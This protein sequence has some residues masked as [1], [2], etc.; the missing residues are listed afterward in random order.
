MNF[1]V[2]RNDD[3]ASKLAYELAIPYLVAKILVNRGISNVEDGRCFLYGDLPDIP[4]PFLFLEM[5]KAVDRIRRAIKR[6]ERIFIFGDYDADGISATA[7]LTRGLA[8]L[9]A[10]VVP[11]IPNRLSHGYG[12]KK[13]YLDLI[14]EKG[15]S[16]VITVDN[17]IKAFDFGEE[18]EREGLDFIITDHH[19]PDEQLPKAFAIIN[20]HVELE[21]YPDKHLAGV[22][23]AFKLLQALFI[24]YGKEAALLPYLKV[25]ALGTVADMVELKGENR[26]L[27]KKGL[28]Q[29]NTSTAYG[30]YH[31]IKSAGLLN[32]KLTTVDIAFRLAPRLNAAG[33]IEDPNLALKLLLSRNEQE[34]QQLAQQLNK[35]NASRQKIEERIL[36]EALQMAEE[37]EDR[38]I[39]L[40][41]PTWHRG[42]IGIVA[43]KLVEKFE[44]PVFLFELSDGIAYGSGRSVEGIPLIEG[45][46]AARQHLLSYGGHELAAGAVLEADKLELVKKIVNEALSSYKPAEK[47]QLVDAELS[48][49]EI[50]PVLVKFISS[51]EPFGIGN[52]E[53]LFIS[54]GIEVVSE[55]TLIGNNFRF[56][57][58]QKERAIPV[59]A[60]GR[61]D[62][63]GKIRKGDLIDLVFNLKESKFSGFELSAVY[64]EKR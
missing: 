53:P 28:E 58:R 46:N 34:A 6:R 40:A 33:R 42:V 22:G 54:K 13:E 12:I 47:V 48:F 9:G 2:H 52:P 18:A 60:R 32:R 56:V 7:L 57:A 39:F 37:V 10:D 23:V 1:V 62:W 26:I 5:E 27:V 8:S 43:H 49:A 30:L 41:S 3:L 16:L 19:L 31:L 59:V 38:V 29:M 51:M 21:P 17:G 50:S 25:V 15:A 14:K 61:S 36:K 55:P 63:L 35:L 20:P 11:F 44:R 4:S 45:L 24:S 64:F